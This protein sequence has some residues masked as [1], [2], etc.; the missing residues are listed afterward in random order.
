MNE[1]EKKEKKTS[2]KGTVKSVKKASS[3]T[4]SKPKSVATKKDSTAKVAKTSVSKST[5]SKTTKKPKAE[6]KVSKT[7]K[8]TE[9]VVPKS[10]PKKEKMEAKKAELSVKQKKVLESQS[11]EVSTISSEEVVAEKK[12]EPKSI[13]NTPISSDVMRVAAIVLAFV[14]I[15]IYLVVMFL[16]VKENTYSSSW[17]GKSYLV[18]KGS[19]RQVYCD[20]LR[21]A[22]TGEASFIYIQPMNDYEKEFELEVELKKIIEDYGLS[23][24]FYVYQLNDN[25]GGVENIYGTAGSYLKIKKGLSKLPTI[26]YYKNGYLVNHIE[27]EDNQMMSGA[28]FVKLLDIYEIKR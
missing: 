7:V 9:K 2:S 15:A 10:A 11:V 20:G 25:C 4:S 27:R 21:E 26:L 6:E 17:D 28:D 14:L 23:K 12:T 19:A 1:N 22:I 16:D 8:K 3:K 5:T 24:K 18:E 13:M